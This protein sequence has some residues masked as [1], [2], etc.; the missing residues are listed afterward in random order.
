MD[1]KHRVLVNMIDTWMLLNTEEANLFFLALRDIEECKNIDGRH[2]HL[3]SKDGDDEFPGTFLAERSG[4]KIVV[5]YVNYSLQKEAQL[6][7]PTIDVVCQISS[8]EDII[9]GH[10]FHKFM[11]RDQF[12]GEMSET[13]E[14]TAKS[15]RNVDHLKFLAA[16]TSDIFIVELATNFFSLFSHF[17]WKNK[18]Q[19]F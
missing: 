2:P 13:L 16:N 3:V 14:K 6:T 10:L 4:S 7:I 1:F 5:T 11:F 9:L 19:W 12:R 17:W 8:L 15:C 18:P